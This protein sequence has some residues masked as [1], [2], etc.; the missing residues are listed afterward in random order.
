MNVSLTGELEKFVNAKVESGRYN[1]ASEVAGKLSA[2]WKNMTRHALLRS[3]GS[4][5]SGRALCT[6]L[7]AA[8]IFL[9]QSPA[10][11][12]IRATAENQGVMQYVLSED[13]GRDWT[14]SGLRHLP[15]KRSVVHPVL[16]VDR[17]S[18][19]KFSRH[20]PLLCD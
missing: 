19:D 7:T 1:S 3:P 20:T 8:S 13:A 2:C 15:K 18:F 11:A 4:T 6:P 5:R 12:Q 17:D 9:R 10:S 14:A 16:E